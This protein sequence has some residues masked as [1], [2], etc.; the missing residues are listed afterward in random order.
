MTDVS[1]RK[2]LSQ[3]ATPQAMMAIRAAAETRW[4]ADKGCDYVTLTD[5]D[6][7][8]NLSGGEFPSD[9]IDIEFLRVTG[10]LAPHLH[11]KSDTAVLVWLASDDVP[12][13][14]CNEKWRTLVDFQII[15]IPAGTPHGFRVGPKGDMFY[16][17]VV[18][19]PKI[20][21]GDT[22]FISI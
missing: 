18:A 10:E 12:E 1:L 6:I 8:Y 3:F 5:D 22:V 7:I 4:I 17:L 21:D 2:L 9:G 16:A 11:Q 15:V 14:W 19:N 13:Q 20:A